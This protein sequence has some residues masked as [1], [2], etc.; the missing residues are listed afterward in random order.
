[1]TLHDLLHSDATLTLLAAAAT[2]LWTFFK[3][4]ECFARLEKR[5]FNSAL[6]A[7][8]AAVAETYE[9]YVRDLKSTRSDGRLSDDERRNARE[10]AYQ[11]ARAI[12]RAQGI[13]LAAALGREAAELWIGKLVRRLKRG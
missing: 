8:E 6:A 1:M 11:R 7:I 2:A 4:T 13:D 9:D 5:R 12:T 3:S 10:K